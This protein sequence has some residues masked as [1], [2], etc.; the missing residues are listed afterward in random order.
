MNNVVELT[1]KISTIKF[2]AALRGGNEHE[3]VTIERGG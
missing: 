2:T 1:H 3:R